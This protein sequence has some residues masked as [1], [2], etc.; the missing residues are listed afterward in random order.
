MLLPLFRAA[1]F[2]TPRFLFGAGLAAVVYVRAETVHGKDSL[3]LP[4]AL[5]YQ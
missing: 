4:A 3:R 2:G 5:T 1:G